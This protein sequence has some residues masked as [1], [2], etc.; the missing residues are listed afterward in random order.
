MLNLIVE[1]G[2]RQGAGCERMQEL[3]LRQAPVPRDN[4][5]SSVVNDETP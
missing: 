3:L 5:V 1:L 2:A 4:V